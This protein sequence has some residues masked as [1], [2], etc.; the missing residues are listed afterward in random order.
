MD[1]HGRRLYVSYVSDIAVATDMAR[2]QAFIFEDY[3]GEIRFYLGLAKIR[4]E[5]GDRVYSEQFDVEHDNDLRRG[6][7]SIRD[8]KLYPV[9][10]RYHSGSTLFRRANKKRLPLF[11]EDAG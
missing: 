6:Q 8:M 11:I 4:S 5:T 9:V 1:Y 3:L 10:K 7:I 2:K